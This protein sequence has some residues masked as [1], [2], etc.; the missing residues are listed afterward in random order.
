MRRYTNLT[1]PPGSPQEL[2]GRTP[3]SARVPLD[4]LLTPPYFFTLGLSSAFKSPSAYCT[5][6]STCSSIGRMA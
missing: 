3:G 4:P 5:P 2:V 1:L 6:A